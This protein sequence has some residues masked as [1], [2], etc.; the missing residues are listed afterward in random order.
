MEFLSILRKPKDRN[1]KYLAV[2]DIDGTVFRSSLLVELME[3]LIDEELISKGA[4]RL[5]K[6]AWKKWQARSGS[7]RSGYSYRKFIENVIVAYTQ[8][9]KGV[10]RSEV[11]RVSE[12]VTNS[13][14]IRL[15]RFTRD[16]IKQ[17][18]KTHFLL[19]IS[20][21]PYEVVAPFAKALGFDKTYALVYEVDKRVRYT[22]TVLYKDIIFNKGKVLRRAIV[23]NKLSLKGSVGVGD[24]E[25]D[26]EFLKIVERP[27]AFNP[28]MKLYKEA[29]KRR[30]EIVVERKDVIYYIKRRH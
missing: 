4:R 21:S 7:A 11:W 3:A 14:K 24:T 19:A 10:R 15:Y 27:I 6:D 2:F 22:G 26:V 8:Y 23:K 18:R 20:H 29:K 28:N 13:N 5:Y 1:K 17:L 9:I 25:T 30:W 12:K 16:L